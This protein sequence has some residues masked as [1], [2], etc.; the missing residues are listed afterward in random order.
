MAIKIINNTAADPSTGLSPCPIIT[1]DY[2]TG[3]EITRFYPD[4]SNATVFGRGLAY[5]GTNLYYT[6]VD[7]TN[8]F[9]TDLIHVCPWNNGAGGPDIRTFPNPLGGGGGFGIPALCYSGGSLYALIGY[10]FQAHVYV[11]Q[12]NPVTGAVIYSVEVLMGGGVS[13][14]SLLVLPN[15]NF[16]CNIDD[17]N[18]TFKQFNRA[19]GA[20]V[21]SPVTFPVQSVSGSYFEPVSGNYFICNVNPSVGLPNFAQVTTSNVFVN[22]S[23]AGGIAGEGIVVIPPPVFAVSCG[24]PPAGTAGVFYSSTLA[25]SGGAAPYSVFI[26]GGGLPPGLSINTTTGLISGFPLAAGTFSFT[27]TVVDNTGAKL[28]VTCSIVIA[29]NSSAFPGTQALPWMLKK[30]VLRLKQDPVLP[31]RGANAALGSGGTTAANSFSL[32]KVVVKI[33]PDPRMPV[34]GA[35]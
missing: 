26:S 12:L 9:A 5:D 16:F 7:P 28:S 29:A 23:P 24:D 30:V 25:I 33:K 27:A 14:D 22:Q 35:Q 20:V 19:T 18:P 34:R 3:L 11:Y 4:G 17:T 1:Y 2:T 15:G 6:S 10:P 32:Q 8:F 13:S 31:V 21:G